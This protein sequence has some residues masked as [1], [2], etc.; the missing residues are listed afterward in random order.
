LKAREELSVRMA[1]RRRLR[2]SPTEAR[3]EG[4]LP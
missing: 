4:Y 3:C 1:G 2:D